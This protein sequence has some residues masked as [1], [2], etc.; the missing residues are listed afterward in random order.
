MNEDV[1]RTMW[2]IDRSTKGIV[3]CVSERYCAA[4]QRRRR[5]YIVKWEDGTRTKP[6]VGG[7]SYDGEDLIII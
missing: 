1:G 6:C 3:T 5:C 4:C 7:C 2:A